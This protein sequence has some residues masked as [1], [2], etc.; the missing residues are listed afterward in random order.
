MIVI[1]K[2]GRFWLVPNGAAKTTAAM[3]DAMTARL[4][5]AITTASRSSR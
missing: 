2:D 4:V 1:R 3:N 5:N